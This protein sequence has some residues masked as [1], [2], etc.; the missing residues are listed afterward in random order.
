ML[1]QRRNILTPLAQSRNL[2]G[3]DTQSV[4]EV[5]TE[6]AVFHRPTGRALE[7]KEEKIPQW[8][9]ERWP[10]FKKGQKRRPHHHRHRRKRTESA[11]ASVPPLGAA[12]PDPG[13]AIPL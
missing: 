3:N 5:L 7:R 11:T 9:R 13:S 1:D 2:D 4:K 8:K 6:L 12:R 10:E